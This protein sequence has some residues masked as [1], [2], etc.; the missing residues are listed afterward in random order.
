MRYKALFL[1]IT[2][3]LLSQIA[4]GGNQSGKPD[5]ASTPVA[6]STITLRYESIRTSVEAPGT[7]Q[8]RNSISLASQINGFVREVRVRVGDAV[9]QNQVLALLDARDA[10]SQKAAAQAAIDEAQAALSEARQSYQAAIQMQTAA[11]ASADLAGQTYARYQKLADSRS[12]S[13]QELDEVGMRR[14]GS[15][16]ELASRAAMVGA[17]EDRIKQVEAKIAQAKAGAGRADVMLSWTEIKAPSS[18]RIVQRL[19]DPG[20]AIFPGSPLL[21]IESIERPQV[22]AEIPTEQSALLRVGSTVKLRDAENG[23]ITDGKISEIVPLSNPATHSMQFK[24]DLPSNIPMPSGRF[25]KVEVPA[26]TRDALLA[27]LTSVRQSGQLTGMFIVDSTSK[28]HFRLVKIAPYDAE[29]VEVL[30]GIDPGEKAVSKLSPQ[31][32]DGIPVTGH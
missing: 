8:P 5:A 32:V 30:S 31:I 18:G 10:Q 14:N 1:V 11:K 3:A 2:V 20:T 24:V 25:V 16:A 7:V 12:V 26:G 13:P 23:T 19:A 4:C 29:R 27:P 21:V 28:A 6:A 15:T 9:R 17:S 22:L